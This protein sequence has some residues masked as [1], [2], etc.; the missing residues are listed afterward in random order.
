[1]TVTMPLKFNGRVHHMDVAIA[2]DPALYHAKMRV[3]TAEIF[4]S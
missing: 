3:G 4:I 1:V 2:A